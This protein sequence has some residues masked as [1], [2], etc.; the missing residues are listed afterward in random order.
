MPASPAT[1][2]ASGAAADPA[3]RGF[4]IYVHWPF[5]LAKCPYCDFNS[6]VR[7]GVDDAAWRAALLAELDH[8]A[9]LTGGRT[10]HSVFF[11]GGTPS[12]M[13]PATVAAVLARI[14]ERWRLAGDA[15]ITLEANPTSAEAG[16]FHA[17]AAAGV[18][19]ISLGIQA[20]N[21]ADLAALG[22]EHSSAEALAALDMAAAAVP[23]WSFDLIYARPGQ[24]LEAWQAELK[25]ALALAGGHLSLYQL[26]IEPGTAFHGRHARGELIVP[27]EDA[28]ADMYALTQESCAAA[29]LPA[30]E[31]S[32]HAAP[33]EQSR[34]NLVYW[35]YG[36]YLGIGPGAHGRVVVDGGRRATAA[37][38]LPE[39]WLAAVREDG[40]GLEREA[41]LDRAE[42][43]SEMLM[44]GLRLDEGVALAA[45]AAETGTAL[46]DWLDADI[47]ARLQAL[48]LIE[49]GAERL[50]LTSR[51]RPLANAVLGELLARP[52]AH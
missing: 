31:I 20:L 32:N 41:S 3:A 52:C 37:W 47:V 12:L 48:D 38:R 42:R 43:A 4:A 51:G 21:D 34:H 15:E 26:T 45:F 46:A 49:L 28:A 24:R 7:A 25:R 30:Y 8:H 23:R 39:R 29:G 5:C 9:A 18:N 2:T 19:R 35:R 14:G 50:R 16:R 10:V 6:H 22:R 27:D 40:H 1:E 11:G 33:G 13:P 44:L 17:L 36:E